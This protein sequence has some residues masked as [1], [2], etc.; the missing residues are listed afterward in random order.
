MRVVLLTCLMSAVAM[1]QEPALDAGAPG[2]RSWDIGVLDLE[3]LLDQDVRAVKVVAASKREETVGDAPATIT[4]ITAEDFA[5]H[6]WRSV[7]EALR[8]VPGVYVSWGRDT[9][10]T[11]VRGLSF[12]GDV[13]TRLLVLIDGHPMNNPWNA[14]SNLG[15][16]LSL[17]PGAVDHVEVVRGPASSVYGSNAF[18]AVVN[19]VTRRPTDKAP[20]R[21][22]VEGL[23]STANAFRLALGGHHRTSFGLEVAGF[24]TLL[25]GDGPTVVFEDMT[26]P[27]LSLGAPTPT[28]GVTRGTDFERGAAAGLSVSF[29]GLTLTGQFHNRWKGLPTAPGAALFNDPF[30]GIAD[31]HLFVELKYGVTLGPLTLSA[32]G[33]LDSFQ[34]RRTLH[35]DPTDWEP[36]TWKYGDVRLVS[37]GLADKWGGEVQAAVQAHEKDIVTAGVEVTSATV[38]QPSFELDPATGQADPATIAG[39]AKDAQG[40]LLPIQPVNVGAYLQNDWRPLASLGIVLGV[41]YDYNTVFT[42]ADAPAAALAPRASIVFKPVDAATLKLSYGEAFR[43]PTPYEAFF[44]DQGSVCGNSAARPER[45]RTVELGGAFN[46]RKAYNLSASAYWSQLQDLLVRQRVDPCYSG[47][48]PRQQFTN[49]G[50]VMVLGAEAAF[51]VRL[52]GVTAFANLG[53]NHAVQTVAGATSRPANS[54]TVVAGAG[55]AVPLVE[56]RIW[57]SGRLHFTSARLN[58]TLDSATIA[59]AAMRVEASLTGR[60]LFGT[61]LTAGLTAAT[62]F[63]VSEVDARFQ[64]WVARDPVTG[65]ETVSTAVPQNAVEVRAHVGF[66]L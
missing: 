45:Q 19:I 51:D 37:Q 8:S 16:V 34:S 50:T 63:K 15:E 65:A 35:L 9:F 42:R 31:R 2:P 56:D 29:K 36:G 55:L 54:P 5:R 23:G 7:A 22:W 66:E 17:P 48:G 21:A 46:F 18:L 28:G 60:R 43:Y 4:V 32:R 30:N 47:S 1:A 26:R 59:P 14:S 53:V 11:G 6:D 33:G 44:D 58:W 24:G 40:K 39:G 20:S 13:D 3:D 49:S 25:T 12:P 57:A 61:G 41:R 38:S 52:A 27:R 10:R 64:D 62:H